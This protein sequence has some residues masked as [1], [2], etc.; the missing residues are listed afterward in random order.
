MNIKN[1]RPLSMDGA[2]PA[3]GRNI[4]HLRP[5]S[6]N[7]RSV[8]CPPAAPYSGTIRRTRPLTDRQREVLAYVAQHIR[9]FGAPPTIREIGTAM[10][11]ASTNGVSDHLHALERKP[12]LSIR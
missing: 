6:L 1:R 5:N 8:V 12:S 11:L 2:S 9:A 3:R 10:G 4:S 7:A